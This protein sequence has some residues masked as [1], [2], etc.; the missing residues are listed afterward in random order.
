MFLLMETMSVQGQGSSRPWSSPVEKNAGMGLYKQII[1]KEGLF[2]LMYTSF[3]Q[4]NPGFANEG[5]HKQ[6]IKASS[7]AEII[8]RG[9]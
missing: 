1:I 5:L 2:F 3:I 7:I 8:S 9:R 4:R 6:Q